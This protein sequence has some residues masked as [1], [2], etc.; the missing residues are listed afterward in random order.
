M[1]QLTVVSVAAILLAVP[2]MAQETQQVDTV[3]RSSPIPVWVVVA[4]ID[5]NPGVHRVH[6]QVLW[7]DPEYKEFRFAKEVEA[8]DFVVWLPK[9]KDDGEE[10]LAKGCPFKST[11][12]EYGL[13]G[14][15][16]A[17]REDTDCLS[18]LVADLPLIGLEHHG[19]QMACEE[20]TRNDGDSKSWIRYF[21]CY[22]AEE[23]EG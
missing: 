7:H 18:V 14:A 15:K 1:R 16:I 4:D 5:D 19:A 20:A 21:G 9:N 10:D 8:G 23:R 13:K 3:S 22:W 12:M 6:I 17:T 2:A 11:H